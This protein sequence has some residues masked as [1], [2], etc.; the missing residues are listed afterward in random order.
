MLLFVLLVALGSAVLLGV[1]AGTLRGLAAACLLA[2]LAVAGFAVPSRRSLHDDA[3]AALAHEPP[4]DREP[5]A[6]DGRDRRGPNRAR[7][8]KRLPARRQPATQGD[9]DDDQWEAF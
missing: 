4:R 6:W 8:V 1:E 2:G 5:A 3:T 7:N 9:L